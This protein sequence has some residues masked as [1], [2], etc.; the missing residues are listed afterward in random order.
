[1]GRLLACVVVPPRTPPPGGGVLLGQFGGRVVQVR[2]AATG[3]VRFTA[4]GPGEDG[5]DLLFSPDGGRLAMLGHDS[6]RGSE[7][8][9]LDVT[10]GRQT[11]SLQHD[12]P[13][14]SWAFS[15][16][17]RT[18]ATGTAGL[19]PGRDGPASAILARVF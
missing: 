7:V 18:L 15:P 14:R 5:T 17:G 6:T 8:R 16:D 12:S 11:A 2:D 4:A 19:P 1:D 9:V 10:D 3:E 13:V